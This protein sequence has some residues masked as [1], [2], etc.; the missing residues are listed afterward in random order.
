MEGLIDSSVEKNNRNGRMLERNG[1]NETIKMRPLKK[2][3][4]KENQGGEGVYI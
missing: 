4:G 1:K 3:G 2:R